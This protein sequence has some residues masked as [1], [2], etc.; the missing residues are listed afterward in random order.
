VIADHHERLRR[1]RR[2]LAGL[3]VGDAFGERFFVRPQLVAG[4]IAQRALPPAPWR[5]TDDTVMALAIAEILEEHGTVDQDA[6]A[7]RFAAKYRQDPGRGYG[8][9]AH[10]ILSDLVAGRPWREVSPAVFDGRGSMGN[11]GAMRAAPVGAYFADDLGEAARQARLSAE[12]THAHREGQAGAMAVAVAAA[13][14]AHG[15][16]SA[17]QLFEAVL[18][19]LPPGPTR[20]GVRAAAA[21]PPERDVREAVATL[22]NGSRVIAEDTVPFALWCAGRHLRDYENALWTTVSGLGDRD[23][24]CAIVGGILALLDRAEIPPHWLAAREPLEVMAAD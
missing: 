24:T 3:S 17:L 10:E 14:A 13:W 20:E 15:A 1:A 9:T 7:A 8:G 16:G 4:L 6:L 11:G 22:G 19:H 18:D 21:L 5:Y 2:S 12:V 23:T